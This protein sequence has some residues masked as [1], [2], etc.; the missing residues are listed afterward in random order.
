MSQTK[1]HLDTQQ[2]IHVHAMII[3]R[4]R[5][6]T[7]S[8][9]CAAGPPAPPVS[10]APPAPPA[11]PDPVGSPPS[12]DASA[13]GFVSP[14]EGAGPR[15]RFN[16]RAAPVPAAGGAVPAGGSEISPSSAKGR[17]CPAAAGAGTAA[18]VVLSFACRVALTPEISQLRRE[19]VEER[20]SAEKE[21]TH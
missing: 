9:H 15:G 11:P 8:T 19:G 21:S 12:F 7:S 1:S 4:L 14:A 5:F 10:A 18:G 13:A 2:R 16:T 20:W 3:P 6:V 17:F